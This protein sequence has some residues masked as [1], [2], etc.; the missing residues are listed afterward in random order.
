MNT[1][2][3][4]QDQVALFNT[5]L[6]SG[7]RSLIVLSAIAPAECDLQR[8]VYFDYLVVHS[9]DFDGAPLS[10]HPENPLRRS[11]L[12]VR[13]RLIERGLRLMQAKGLISASYTGTG[14]LYRTTNV[15]DAFL[16]YLQS[17]YS[18][19]LREAANW[20]ATAIQPLP[21]EELKRL[22]SVTVGPWGAEF[23]GDISEG[24]EPQ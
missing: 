20:I 22:L 14:I 23:E 4:E 15:A 11:E 1:G 7:L 13:R 8:L 2:I 16:S 17:A 18:S 10:L 3:G 24:E 12:L 5:P 21:D 9:G 6:E 19:R